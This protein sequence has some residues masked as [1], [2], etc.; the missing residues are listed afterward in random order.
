MTDFL[1]LQDFEVREVRLCTRDAALK[2]AGFLRWRPDA[3]FSLD[4]VILDR[5][6]N[7]VVERIDIPSGP[8]FRSVTTARLSL[9]ESDWAFMPVRDLRQDMDFWAGHTITRTSG[10]VLFRRQDRGSGSDDSR[11]H[12]GASFRVLPHT[13]LP[14][15]VAED[16]TINGRRTRQQFRRAGL[17]VEMKGGWLRGELQEPN[18]L[19]AWWTLERGAWPRGTDWRSAGAVGYALG[20]LTGQRMW[21]VRRQTNRGQRQYEEVRWVTRSAQNLGFQAPCADFADV[22]QAVRAMSDTRYGG[23]RTGAGRWG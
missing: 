9:G 21:L 14:D 6:T 16:V 15:L 19:N 2:G 13:T 4:A 8:T 11:W 20:I 10:V 18:I 17:D 7:R 3:G 23:C 12:C 1:Q 5:K 22:G